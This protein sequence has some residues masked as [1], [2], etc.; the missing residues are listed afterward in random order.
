MNL[1]LLSADKARLFGLDPQ[2]TTEAE[3]FDALQVDHP[4]WT[5]EEVQAHL[6][7]AIAA[8]AFAREE[9]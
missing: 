1:K 4:R 5:G 6:N 3:A 8:G 2:D 9:Q 7:E